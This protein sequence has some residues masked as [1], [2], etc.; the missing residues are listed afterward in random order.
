MSDA[1][2]SPRSEPLTPAVFYILLALA[3]QDRHGY[4]IMKQAESDS[5]GQIHLGPGTLYGT[6]KRLLA[7]G[8][9]VEAG[10]QTDPELDDQRR[11]Y[12]RLSPS[13][14][15]LLGLELERLEHAVEAARQQHILPH[16][17]LDGN[18]GRD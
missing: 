6:I 8:H 2:R 7:A 12:Y 5:S 3:T 14:R 9:I 18:L 1:T 11:R 16:H 10:E 13:G 4:G 17:K 15:Q